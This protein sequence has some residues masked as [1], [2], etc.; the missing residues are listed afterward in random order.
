LPYQATADCCCCLLLLLLLQ[1]QIV[2]Q[3]QATVVFLD[4][5]YKPV[6]VPAN[7]KEALIQLQQEYKDGL[8]QQ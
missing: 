8:T 6:R 5:S 3:G 7:V 4:A 2:C 1:S